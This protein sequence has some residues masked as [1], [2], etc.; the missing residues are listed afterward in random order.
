M[1]LLGNLFGEEDERVM[2][3][4]FWTN[5]VSTISTVHKERNPAILS[6]AEVMQHERRGRKTCLCLCFCCFLPTNRSAEWT[7]FVPYTKS[8]HLGGALEVKSYL[9]AKYTSSWLAVGICAP[10]W[11]K[12]PSI[13]YTMKLVHSAHCVMLSELTLR[14]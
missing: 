7:S 1:I 13:G 8:P 5:S 3:G 10:T 9:G 11:R 14:P 12:R 6:V 2:I 4:K